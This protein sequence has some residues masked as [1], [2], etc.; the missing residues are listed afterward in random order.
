MTDSKPSGVQPP[1]TAPKDGTMI[2]LLVDYTGQD[3]WTPLEDEEQAWTI[4]Y[5][6]LEDQDEDEWI[7]VG[8]NWEQDCYTQGAGK[9][10]GWLPFHTQP[11]TSAAARDVL[12]ERQRQISAEGWTPEHDDLYVDG[13]MAAAAACYTINAAGWAQKVLTPLS[14]LWPW[15]KSW[16]KP[17]T[18]RRD[19]VK[20]GA[21]ILAE[22][23]RLDRKEGTPHMTDTPNLS[24]AAMRTR[25]AD[26][27]DAQSSVFSSTEYA[28]GQPLSSFKERFACGQVK[29]AILTLPLE[30]DHADLLAEALKLPGIAALVEAAWEAAAVIAE[31]HGAYPELNIINGGPDWFK[32]GKSIAAAIRAALVQP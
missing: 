1:D 15:A 8:W 28:T 21:L 12:A 24:A 26:V 4:G 17:T 10:I 18:P 27:C 30:A 31:N 3:R 11:A 6:T 25:A 23:E 7:M 13:E 32:H 2:R 20:A 22:I 9:I 16:W 19:L 29:D 14:M 5:N